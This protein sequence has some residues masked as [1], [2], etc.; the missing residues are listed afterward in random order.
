MKIASFL[1]LTVNFLKLWHD[2][3]IW[4]TDS[5]SISKKNWRKWLICSGVEKINHF[6]SNSVTKHMYISCTDLLIT[7]EATLLSTDLYHET[8]INVH[9]CNYLDFPYMW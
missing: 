2:G 4:K 7:F 1:I 6:L 9:K 5:Y 8:A 3:A